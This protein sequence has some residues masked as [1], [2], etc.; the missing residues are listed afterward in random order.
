MQ[1]LEKNRNNLLVVD[2]THE[3]PHN[4]FLFNQLDLGSKQ[5][6]LTFTNTPN[7]WGAKEREPENVK[8]SY[9]ESKREP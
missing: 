8:E 5:T 2:N 4:F 9:G 7:E 6:N 1:K 3:Q